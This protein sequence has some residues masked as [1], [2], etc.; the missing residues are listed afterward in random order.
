MPKWSK[1]SRVEGLDDDDGKWYP[2]TIGAVHRDGTYRLNWQG[3]LAGTYAAHIH[4]GKIRP[5]QSGLPLPLSLH[6]RMKQAKPVT[7]KNTWAF[8]DLT[9]ALPSQESKTVPPRTST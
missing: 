1:G 5:R 2:A 4:E 8:S 7:Q 9:R 3:K 6:L